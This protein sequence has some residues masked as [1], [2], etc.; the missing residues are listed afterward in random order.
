[1]IKKFDIESERA[2]LLRRLNEIPGIAIDADRV[3]GM[4]STPSDDLIG[5]ERHQQLLRTLPWMI[6][7]IRAT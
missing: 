2:E 5:K 3:V 6:G 7:A 1:M 4:R